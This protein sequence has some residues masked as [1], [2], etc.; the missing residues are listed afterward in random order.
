MF[1]KPRRVTAVHPTEM[2]RKTP[3]LRAPP[4]AVCVLP[5]A[6]FKAWKAACCSFIVLAGEIP[7]RNAGMTNLK[8]RS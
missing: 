6:F 7:A 4:R 3:R 5:V 2:K 8:E 1:F